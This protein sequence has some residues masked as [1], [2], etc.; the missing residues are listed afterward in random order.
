MN[1]SMEYKYKLYKLLKTYDG[2]MIDHIDYNG[3][4]ITRC[5]FC[6]DSSDKS[7]GHLYILGLNEDS[8]YDPNYYCQKCK[9]Q[10]FI[11]EFFLDLMDLYDPELHILAQKHKINKSKHNVKVGLK[12]NNKIVSKLLPPLNNSNTLN[13]IKIFEERMGVKLTT[14]KILY[15]KMVFNLHDYLEYNNIRKFT[16]DKRV[17][18]VLDDRY[19]GFLSVNNEFINMRNFG[20]V[21]KYNKRYENYNV[22][23][24]QDNTKRFYIISNKIDVM[25][26]VT[27]HICEGV[28]DLI[29]I[30]EHVCNCNDDNV[31]YAA[32]LGLSYSNII[33][34]IVK[35][36]ILFADYNIYS[37]SGIPI[38]EYRELKRELKDII[39]GEFNI[40]YNTHPKYKDCGT[41]KENIILKKYML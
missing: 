7:H 31:I 32:C 1:S 29:G 20:E 10:G 38:S 36:G 13:K 37:D 25:K 24:I 23:G 21:T 5:Q 41:K 40:Y 27:V 8:P 19:I 4:M 35:K 2:L 34:Y 26:N 18:D 11:D 6:G 3:T 22:Y 16:R 15:Y 12:E 33:K 28:F 9:T 17:V 39:R 14:E 30:R